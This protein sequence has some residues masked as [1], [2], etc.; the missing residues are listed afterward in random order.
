MISERGIK[1]EWALQDL[2]Q[3]TQRTAGKELINTPKSK[4]VLNK[5]LKPE[6]APDLNQLWDKLPAE[7]KDAIMKLK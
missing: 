4:R 6:K 2:N 7:I 1:N 3:N 5:V